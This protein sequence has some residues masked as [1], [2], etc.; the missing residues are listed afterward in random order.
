MQEV[1]QAFCFSIL[2][3]TQNIIRLQKAAVIRHAQIADRRHGR[4]QG[5]LVIV[6]VVFYMNCQER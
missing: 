5:L 2:A 6:L 4:F 1:S 3:K